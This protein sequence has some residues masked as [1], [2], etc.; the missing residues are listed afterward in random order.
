MQAM[1]KEPL[2]PAKSLTLLKKKKADSWWTLENA[3]LSFEMSL[4]DSQRHELQSIQTVP[5]SDAVL[6][7]TAHLDSQNRDRKGPSIASRL[8]SVLQSARDFADV[9]D[10]ITS[11]HS[12]LS[13]LVWGIMRITILVRFKQ[14]LTSPGPRG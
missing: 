4:S 2:R 12:K 9:V 5:D 14:M 13:L 6:I 11:S 1:P 7:F 10:H 8:F 3:I